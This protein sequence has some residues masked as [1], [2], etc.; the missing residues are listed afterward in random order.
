MIPLEVKRM[1]EAIERKR[2]EELSE[3]LNEA[4]SNSKR[5]IGESKGETENIRKKILAE[6]EKRAESVRGKN[7]A[8]VELGKRAEMKVLK[9]EIINRIKERA[10]DASLGPG[11]DGLFEDLFEKALKDMGNGD[12]Q[13]LVRK[14]DVPLVKRLARERKVRVSVR[15]IEATGGLVVISGKRTSNHLLDDIVERKANEIDTELNKIL[16]SG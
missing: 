7:I 9:S 5:I 6:Y 12:L 13:V 8:E 10:I 1:V 14:K 3:I 4:K 2:E 15:E 11:Y 16:F